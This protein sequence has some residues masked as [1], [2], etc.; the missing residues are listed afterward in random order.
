MPFIND[1]CFTLSGVFDEPPSPLTMAVE[2][3]VATFYCQHSA[4]NSIDWRVNGTF[5]NRIT[6]PN[7]SRGEHQVDAGARIYSISIATSLEY[8]M[9]RVEC[10]AYFSSGPPLTSPVVMLLIQGSYKTSSV[11]AYV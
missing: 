11:I 6:S 10:V 3:G 8:N 1:M 4:C 5:F 7:I 2:E 9:S